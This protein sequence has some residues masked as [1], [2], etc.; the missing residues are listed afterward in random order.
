MKMVTDYR[1]PGS[2]IASMRETPA[3]VKKKGERSGKE[4][5]GAVKR[6]KQGEDGL[7]DGTETE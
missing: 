2:R 1:L 6:I 4:N 3:K 5:R 7:F